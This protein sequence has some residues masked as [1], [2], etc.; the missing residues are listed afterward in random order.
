MITQERLKELFTY[1]GQSLIW[2]VESPT[3]LKVGCVAG[4]LSKDSDYISIGFDKKIY[5]AHRMI[6]L[7][8]HGYLPEFLDHIDGNKVNNRIKNLRACTVQQNNHNTKMPKTNTS[9]VKG[10]CWDKK[11]KVWRA[12]IRINYKN[13]DLGCFWDIETAAQVVRIERFKLHGEFANNG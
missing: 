6:F 8:C 4:F 1:D 3:R 7:Y 10:V 12:R 2:K 13:N 11:A 5:R 9:G